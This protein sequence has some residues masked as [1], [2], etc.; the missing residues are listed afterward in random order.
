PRPANAWILYRSDKI[1]ELRKG[2]PQR[3]LSKQVSA[4]WRNE[5]PDVR[6]WYEKR[7]EEKKQEHRRM[8]PD[9]RFQPVKKEE[10]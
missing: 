4:L 1:K 5:R 3:D 2:T 9:Y 8:Y 6:A 10:K 7:A